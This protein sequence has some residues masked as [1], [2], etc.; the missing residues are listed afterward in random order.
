[1]GVPPRVA[2]YGDTCTSHSNDIEKILTTLSLQVM[3]L[4]HTNQL[5]SD[6]PF[7]FS[8]RATRGTLI[9]FCY[10][11][12]VK[13]VSTFKRIVDRTIIY[14]GEKFKTD[15]TFG[16]EVVELTAIGNIEAH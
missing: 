11:L 16:H 13:G 15:G 5:E 9:A 1:M 3:T 6:N 2:M 8:S 10:A 14:V 4:L 7:H 12:V